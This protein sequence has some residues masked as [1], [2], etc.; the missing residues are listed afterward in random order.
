MTVGRRDGRLLV[1]WDGDPRAELAVGDTVKP[2]SAEA[3][4]EL[5]ASA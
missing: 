5:K 1:D 2:T 4:R 3:I